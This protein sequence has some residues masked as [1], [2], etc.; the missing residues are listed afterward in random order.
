MN[1]GMQNHGI[2]MPIC[3]STERRALPGGC[4]CYPSCMSS[5]ATFGDASAGGIPEEA[6][7]A[8]PDML[9][10]IVIMKFKSI[11]F[12]NVKKTRFQITL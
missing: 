9:I 8:S 4:L 1:N 5:H 3:N 2:A 11:S 12:E 7:E 6:P 10:S